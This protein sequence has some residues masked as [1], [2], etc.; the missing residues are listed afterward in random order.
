MWIEKQPC[1]AFLYPP[2]FYLAEEDKTKQ[3]KVSFYGIAQGLEINNIFFYTILSLSF[4][5]ANVW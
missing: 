5:K 2:K 1:K 4:N 3:K